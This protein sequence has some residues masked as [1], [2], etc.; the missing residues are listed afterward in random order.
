VDG[1]VARDA[2]RHGGALAALIVFAVHCTV[3][4]CAQIPANAALAFALAG[5]LSG[6]AGWAA[7]SR[8]RRAPGRA[9]VGLGSAVRRAGALSA[10]PAVGAWY[11]REAALAPVAAR[12]ALLLRAVAWDSRP[13]YLYRVGLNHFDRAEAGDAR[14][15]LMRDGLRHAQAALALDP[16]IRTFLFG[17]DVPVAPGQRERG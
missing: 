15:V 16:S 11:A 17:G 9:G 10:R 1:E 12:G 8:P 6:A 14:P 13:E 7:R 2:R 3:D 4:F 5:W